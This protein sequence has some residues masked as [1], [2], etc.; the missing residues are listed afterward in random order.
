MK[1][2]TGNPNLSIGAHVCRTSDQFILQCSNTSQLMHFV[3]YSLAALTL[4]LYFYLC[5]TSFSTD[6]DSCAF[7]ILYNVFL[8]KHVPLFFPNTTSS[9]FMIFT[10]AIS[11]SYVIS[12]SYQSAA[13][14]F[15][16]YE[17]SSPLVGHLWNRTYICEPGGH[18]NSP[19]FL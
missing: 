11:S 16:F 7:A 18:S 14:V 8:T 1:C 17:C 13:L 9:T 12:N 2:C 19:L 6:T 10:S 15:F 4:Q 3:P 5:L